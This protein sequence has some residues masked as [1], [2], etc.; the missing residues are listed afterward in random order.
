MPRVVPATGYDL[1]ALAPLAEAIFAGADDAGPPGQAVPTWPRGQAGALIHPGQATWPGGQ[2][3]SFAHPGQATWPEG[4]ADSFAH[5]DLATWPERQADSFAHLGQATWPGGQ[6]DP[7]AHPGPADALAALLG[8]PRREPGWFARKLAREAVDPRLSALVLGTGDEPVGYMLVGAGEADTGVVHGA[9]LGLLPAWRG[10]GLGPALVE[11]NCRRLAAAGISAVR[12][13]AD[14]DHRGFYLRHG[15]DELAELQTLGAPG[16]GAADLDLTAA[17]HAR[18]PWPLP[19]ITHA[20][21]SAGTWERTPSARAATLRL[22]DHAAAHVSREGRAVLVH[23]LAVA[24]DEHLHAALRR[25]RGSF[26]AA[27]PVLL[28]GCAPVSPVTALCHADGWH[29]LQRAHVMQRRFW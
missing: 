21:W 14:P 29:L 18:R 2:A 3:D 12:L 22:G 11:A 4:Q 5:P 9:G 10:R 19:G 1:A 15:F 7:L 26:S 23:R 8:P 6:A 17:A 13:L 16:A 27:T 24:A 25:L 20:A 28:H